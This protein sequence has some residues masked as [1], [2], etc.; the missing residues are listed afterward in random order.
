MILLFVQ[1]TRK[2]KYAFM[3]VKEN[4]KGAM[5]GKDIL[6]FLLLLRYGNLFSDL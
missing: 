2:P 5:N 1:V 6:L 4:F 3:E